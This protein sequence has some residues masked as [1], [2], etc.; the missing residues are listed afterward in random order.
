[1]TGRLIEADK[2][3]QRLRNDPLFESIE[4]FGV[5]GVI[6]A[7][8]T[9][10]AIPVEW[11]KQFIKKENIHIIHKVGIVHMV[12]QW[13][14]H[15][16][17]FEISSEPQWIP[18]SEQLPDFG[19]DVLVCDGEGVQVT[20]KRTWWS[21]DPNGWATNYCGYDYDSWDFMTNGDIVAWMELP[22]PYEVKEE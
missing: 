8:P 18:V 2:L 10:D 4:Q 12:E 14:L 5:I 21:T 1:M 22:K 15:P 11:I 3:I 6:E 20:A 13:K 19:V 17:D 16:I 7:E 9:V